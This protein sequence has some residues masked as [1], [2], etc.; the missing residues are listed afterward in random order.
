MR[1]AIKKTAAQLGRLGLL[2][3]AVG[4]HLGA[5]R[6]VAH[7]APRPLLLVLQQAFEGSALLLQKL[8]Q[9]LGPHRGLRTRLAHG[10]E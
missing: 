5:R 8:L 2:V 10:M 4:Q 1:R 7:L 9:R 3:V 6:V